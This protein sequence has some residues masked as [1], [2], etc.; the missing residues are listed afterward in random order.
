MKKVTITLTLECRD[1]IPPHIARWMAGN[2]EEHAAYEFGRDY[3]PRWHDLDD[4]A[5]PP[6]VGMEA[7]QLAV[8]GVP[9]PYHPGMDLCV[10]WKRIS[11]HRPRHRRNQWTDSSSRYLMNGIT[12]YDTRY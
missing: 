3:Q 5:P 1:D 8:D 9:K 11:S 12:E 4:D 10:V 6:L 2:L 7:T